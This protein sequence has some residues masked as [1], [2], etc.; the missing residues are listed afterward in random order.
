MC[1]GVQAARS[2]GTSDRVSGQY[3]TRRRYQGLIDF[4]VKGLSMKEGRKNLV[5]QA[6]YSHSEVK[7]CGPCSLCN[8]CRSLCGYG[9]TAASALALCIM[10]FLLMHC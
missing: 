10:C 4:A 9:V 7:T 2:S 3:D 8:D 5:I 6:G 1:L